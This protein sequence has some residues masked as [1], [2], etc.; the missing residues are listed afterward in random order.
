[1]RGRR[2]ERGRGRKGEG[3][4]GGDRG[5][6]E[7]REGEREKER[8][9]EGERERGRAE[10]GE[11]TRERGGEESQESTNFDNSINYNKNT[12]LILTIQASTSP[13]HLH[14]ISPF[15]LISLARA[16]ASKV[17]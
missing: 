12:T 2:R 4:E 10:R 3:R 14:Y 9:R 16:I 1:M 15:I 13:L 17:L 5:R 7:G 11:R 6:E 8:G